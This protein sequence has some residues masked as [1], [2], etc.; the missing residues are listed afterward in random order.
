M[1]VVLTGGGR[2]REDADDAWGGRQPHRGDADDTRDRFEP[3]DASVT[4]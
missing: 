2:A 3:D 4:T 1:R